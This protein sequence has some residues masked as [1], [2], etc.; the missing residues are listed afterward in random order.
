MTKRYGFNEQDAKQFLKNNIVHDAKVLKAEFIPIV[1]K[2]PGGYQMDTFINEKQKGGRNY[3]MLIN[4]NTRKAYAY[5]LI[6]KGS[7]SVI[8]ALTK[9][10]ND[11]EAVHSITSD[12]D[13]A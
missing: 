3:L 12:Q 8:E 10:F 11:V 1:S 4:I 7:K 5:P 2:Y 13:A 9:F 6:G